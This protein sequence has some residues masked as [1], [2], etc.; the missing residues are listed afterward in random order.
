MWEILFDRLRKPVLQLLAVVLALSLTLCG[1]ASSEYSPTSLR[2]S[3]VEYQRPDG[4]AVLDLIDQASQQAQED[5]LPFGLLFSLR[6]ISQATEEFYGMMTIAQIRNYADMSDSFYSEEMEYLNTWDA[7]I[8]NRY[9]ELFET[10]EQSRFGSMTQDIFGESATEDLQMSASASSQE[11]LALQEQEKQLEAQYYS[12][13]ATATVTTPEGEQTYSSLE[14]QAKEAYYNQFI[15]KYNQ[16]LGELYRELV[17]LRRQMAQ[18]LGYDSYTQMADLEM[19]RVGYD[20]EDIQQFREQLKQTLVP[21]YRS[22]LQDFYD[23]AE[24]RENPGVV[25]LLEEEAPDPQGGWQQTLQ[26]LQDVYEQMSERTGECYTYLLSH[27]MIDAA[28]SAVKANVTFSTMLYSLNTPF[29]FANMDGSSQDVFSISHE[30][31]HCYAMWRQLEQGSREE[32]RSMDVCEIHSQAMQ[33]LTMPYYEAFYGEQ[34]GTARR[35]DVYTVAA[36]ILTAALND[37]FQEVVYASDNLTLDQL[38]ELYAS[39]AEEYGLVVDSPYYDMDSFSKSW[40]TTNQYFDS[41]FY[42]IDYALS[43]CVA[44]Q[45]L[46]LGLQDYSDALQCYDALVTQDAGESFLS[47][48]DGVGLTSPFAEGALEELAQTLQD[49]LN[50]DGSFPAQQPDALQE[51]A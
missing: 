40:F 50:G 6:K 1:C 12:E 2:F 4:Q 24:S 25:Y 35:Y 23:R 27:E 29:L 36:G 9:N 46:S 15:D 37:E 19:L 3:Q 44:M 14:P 49:F 28:P 16:Q 51:A 18:A 17:S 45:F 22:Y 21:I 38:N 43:G 10:I 39:L 47:V 33:I 11:I 34:A 5:W 31:G 13:Y 41:P 48:L 8:Q 30:F 20:R 42:A 32:G 26:N 7:R